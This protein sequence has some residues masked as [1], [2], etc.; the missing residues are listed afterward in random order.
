MNVV[1]SGFLIRFRLLTA[2]LDFNFKKY[3]F[4]E[5]RFRNS[6]VCKSSISANTNINQESLKKLQI[7]LPPLPEQQ[8]IAAILSTWDAAIASLEQLITAKEHHKKGL[9]QVLLTSP[10]DG[11]AGKKRFAGFSD[12]WDLKRLDEITKKITDGAHTSPKTSKID[13]DYPIY[14]V[15]NMTDLNL[16]RSEPRYISKSDFNDL[17]RQGCQ[18]LRNDVLIAK[19]GS[20]LKYSFVMKEDLKGVILSSIAIIRVDLTR[21]NP[22]YLVNYFKQD[23]VQTYVVKALTSGSGVPRIILRDFRSLKIPIPSLP[24]QQKIAAVLSAAD[25]EIE[26]LKTQLTAIQHQKKGLMQKLLSGVVRVK[27]K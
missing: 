25:T 4:N 21:L 19:D 24:E 11:Q 16:S 20:I 12:E 6:L 17:A 7:P 1:Y 14:S 23:I 13:K 2:D 10:K 3:C 5:A 8:K 18:P 15:K 22:H 26:Q 27:I 9:M